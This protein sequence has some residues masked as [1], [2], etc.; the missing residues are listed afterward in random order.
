[1]KYLW[2]LLFLLPVTL[3][4]KTI[5]VAVIDAGFNPSV[6]KS[7]NLCP[8][9]NHFSFSKNLPKFYKNHG[10]NVAGL[11]EKYAG[12]SNYCLILIEGIG[13]S[14][15]LSVNAFKTAINNNVDVINYSGGGAGE[16][17][18]EKEIVKKFLDNGGTIFAAAGN[19]GKNL[20]SICYYYPAC[21]DKRIN[22]IGNN[23]KYSNTGKIVKVE[24]LDGGGNVVYG[25]ELT[26]TSQ[27]TA[28]ATGIYIRK[29]ND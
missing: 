15:S 10:T 11:I 25:I 3:Y 17:F 27:S 2:T 26:G 20:D 7:K 23:H 9:K 13:G 5:K 22:V 4:G 8:G 18:F 16:K 19:D 21:Y 14:D 6:L 12:G 24:M 29:N 1:M 28:I